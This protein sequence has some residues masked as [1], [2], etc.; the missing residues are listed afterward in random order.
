MGGVFAVTSSIRGHRVAR[1]GIVRWS[2]LFR[3]VGGVFAVTRSIRGHRVARW[4]TCL[5][6]RLCTLGLVV[7][8]VRSFILTLGLGL[9][10]VFVLLRNGLGLGS[11]GSP[12]LLAFPMMPE[13][14]PTSTR[15]TVLRL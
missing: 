8:V 7:M 13:A 2:F 5:W 9:I 4:E 6:R 3:G 12:F 1:W 11:C 15:C 14:E 10:L